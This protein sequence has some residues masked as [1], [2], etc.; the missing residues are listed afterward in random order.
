MET[1]VCSKCNIEK[2]LSNFRKRKDSKDGFRTECKQCSYLVW[3]KYRDN[4]DE[5]IKDQKRKEYVDNREKIL[6]KVKNYREEN[7]DVIR[8]KDN[9]RSKKRYQKD[10]NRSKIYYEKNKENILTYKKEWSEKNKEKVK[11]KR[12][13]YHSLRLK[14]DVIFRLKCV[15]RSRLLSFLKTRNI[16]KKDKT[17]DIVGCSPEFL[18]EHLE[19]QFISGMTWDNRSEWHIDHIIPLSSAKTE[20]ELY[21]LC[22]YENLQPLWAED[23]LKKS[24]KIFLQTI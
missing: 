22:Y 23:N 19:K 18:K 5:K 7:I 13:L 3:K 6:L 12:N 17:F 20:D 8:I 21:K 14:N 10:P 2:E 1:K 11:V 24:N 9:D 4:N 15:M 16:T